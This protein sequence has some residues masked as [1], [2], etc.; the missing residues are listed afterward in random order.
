MDKIVVTG[1]AG[2]IGSN[3]IKY[4][5]SNAISDILIVDNINDNIEKQKLLEKIKF[6]EIITIENF[7][8]DLN[9]Y[10]NVS[11]IFHQGACSDT[12]N[13]DINFMMK[14]NFEY[15]KNILFHS[16]NNNINFLFAS[17]GSVYGEGS[18]GFKEKRECEAPLNIYA[19]SK[20]EMDLI[21]R[22][23]LCQKISSQV[24]SLRYFNVYG[25]PEIHKGRMASVPFHFFNQFKQIGRI[26]IFEGSENFKRD[27][28][29]I[30]DILNIIDYFYKNKISGIY[31]AGTGKV[32]SFQKM[33]MV[34]RKLYPDVNIEVIPFPENLKKHYQKFTQ[35]DT[36]QLFS[37]GFSEPFTTLEEGLENY[38]YL[39]EEKH[40]NS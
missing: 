31:N 22:D 29:Y 10:K 9:N 16:L 13:H 2:F 17:S 15:S 33:A 40:Y 7:K 36:S 18:N 24:V 6:K 34:T 32:N 4:L 8:K 38:Y 12:M 30:D 37:T 3:I 14:N 11:H 35:A 25:Y 23:V 21:I 28:I 27:F 5:N 20:L 19:K 1:G 39:L 26:K